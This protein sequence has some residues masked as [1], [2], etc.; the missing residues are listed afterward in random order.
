MARIPLVEL[1]YSH[2]PGAKPTIN[3]GADTDLV[4]GEIALNIADRILFTRTGSGEDTSADTIVETK[5]DVAA[6]AELTDVVIADAEANQVLTVN[7]D[8]KWANITLTPAM[9]SGLDTFIKN[10]ALPLTG[11]V[12][13]GK[14]TYGAQ[15]G[16]SFEDQ[17]LVTKKYVDS[18]ASAYNPHPECQTAANS[19]IDGVYTAGSVAGKPGVGATFVLTAT[20]GNNTVIN[21][22]I[23]ME[24]MRVLLI[25]QTDKK[26]NGAYTVTT[27]PAGEGQVVLTRAEDFD[28]DPKIAYRGASFLVAQGTLK[29]CVYRLVE[30][31]VI[32]GTTEI[33]FIQTY[34]PTTYTGGDGVVINNNIISV[35]QG[36]TVK[37]IDS[38]LEVASG[39]GNEGKVLTAGTDGQ[40]AEWKEVD[41]SNFATLD[42][43]N[44]IFSVT[45]KS[46]AAQDANGAD[47]NELAKISTVKAIS[48]AT[49]ESVTY[50]D[51]SDTGAT[52]AVGGISKGEKLTNVTFSQFA[53]K[54]LHP[55]VAPSGVGL[56]L[57]P[58]NGGV[59][60]MGGPKNVASATVRWTNGSQLVSKAEVLSGST[61]LGE[62][63]LSA[64][65]T[66]A[67]VTFTDNVS[68]NKSYT[69]RITDP[70]KSYNGG[71]VSF[72][73]VYPM[74]QGVLAS[75]T[76]LDSA[77][78]TSL[79]KVV[80]TKGN[81][82][83]KYT[84]AGVQQVVFAFPTSYGNLTS[85][86]DQNN[87][88]NLNAFTKSVVQVTG[89]DGTAQSYNVYV[90]ETNIDNFGYTFKF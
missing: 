34:A 49:A 90:C 59:F 3:T 42:G 17:D 48:Q 20:T 36:A 89:L 50:T 65:A 54:L 10:H 41:F 52:V 39:I 67:V 58:T 79:T 74:Y 72:T 13:T 47:G 83:Y 27:V 12:L 25:G 75:G 64:S 44:N 81:K 24:G 73:F 85:I 77:S 57:S 35:K 45:P 6:L 5:L 7:A 9:I 16:E 19:N 62:T 82:T 21:G 1:F 28:G 26:Q 29:G 2:T 15:V 4:R 70:T 84:T 55:Y 51:E 30:D 46:A 37:V 33:N 40:A 60:E 76:A 22:V 86:M 69:A 23:L 61:V 18:I 87:F 53:D 8:G 71:N 56:T 66:S 43:Q 31:A 80:Q 14:V 63:P 78:I 11:G 38:N 88:E 68:A 32:F